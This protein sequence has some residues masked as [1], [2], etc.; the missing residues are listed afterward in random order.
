LESWE[1][2]W[3]REEPLLPGA[4]V[5]EILWGSSI[6]EMRKYDFL[7]KSEKL[8]RKAGDAG[9][10]GRRSAG[11]GAS[12]RNARAWWLWF[13]AVTRTVPLAFSDRET[14]VPLSPR[15]PGTSSQGR[16]L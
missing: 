8:A 5:V 10:H 16:I 4:E 7:G 14:Y 13:S 3:A 11:A 15:T 6:M 2:E 1:R 9:T 12:K